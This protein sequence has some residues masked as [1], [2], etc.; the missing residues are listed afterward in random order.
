M[1]PF[2]FFAAFFVCLFVTPAW[3]VISLTSPTDQ[4]TSIRLGDRNDYTGDEQAQS[5][6]GDIV[7]DEFGYQDGF[8]KKYDYGTSVGIGDDELAFRVRL[9]DDGA[10]HAFI[11]FDIGVNGVNGGL[12]D[13]TIDMFIDASFGQATNAKNLIG[14]YKAEGGLNNSPSTTSISKFVDLYKNASDPTFSDYSNLSLVSA[15]NDSYIAA[16]P[17]DPNLPT[18]S[19]LLDIDG[20]SVNDIFFSF[21]VPM[22][23]LNA[24]YLGYYPGNDALTDTTLM[25]FVLITAN[26]PNSLNQDFGGLPKTFTDDTWVNLGAINAPGEVPEPASYTLIFGLCALGLVAGRQRKLITSTSF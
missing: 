21:K 26:Q 8:Y 5:S 11:G 20:N 19:P 10:A 7:G 9:A 12:P 4:W 24:A 6:G 3:A 18:L 14:F 1:S 2:R 17:I 23:E 22:S 15:S 13:G 25:S 16:N